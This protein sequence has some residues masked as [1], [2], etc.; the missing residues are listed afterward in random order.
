MSFRDLLLFAWGA[1]RG[2]RLRTLLCVTGIAV[3]IAAVL[4]LVSLGEGAR[5]Y[6]TRGLL[7][8]A[9]SRCGPSP[10]T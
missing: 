2:H 9:L 3:G 7:A 10:A 4:L 5:I 6:V 8:S 1:L